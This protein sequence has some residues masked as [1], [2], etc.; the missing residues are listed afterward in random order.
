MIFQLSGAYGSVISKDE[1]NDILRTYIGI[2]EMDE[3]V[4]SGSLIL[5]PHLITPLYNKEEYP[6]RTLWESRENIEQLMVAINNIGE[7]GLDPEDYHI[8][9]IESLHEQIYLSELT[10]AASIAR[11]DILLTDAFILLSAHLAA[12]KVDP[13]TNEPRW[14]LSGDDIGINWCE[15]VKNSLQNNNVSDNLQLI[16]PRHSSYNNLKYALNRYQKIKEEGGWKTFSTDM[17]RLKPGMKHPDIPAVRLRLAATQDTAGNDKAEKELFDSILVEQVKL[18]QKR[19]GLTPRGVV[20]SATI[21]QM[22]IPVEERISGIKVNLDRWR[23]FG[24][25]LGYRYIK[26]NIPDF[27]LRVTENDST[28]LEARVIVGRTNRQTPSFSSVM[29]YMEFNPDWTVPPTMLIEDVLPAIREDP[30][31]LERNNMNVYGEDWNPVNPDTIDWQIYDNNDFPYYIVQEPGPQN[32]LGNIKF[33]FPNP[34]HVYIHDTP[35]PALFDEPV[36]TFSSGCIRVDKPVEL[37]AYLLEDSPVWTPKY[38]EIVMEVGLEITVNIL[39]P[40]Q[41]YIIYSTAWAGDEGLVYFRDDIYE[42]D[43]KLFTALKQPPPG[44]IQY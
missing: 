28:M 32:P 17:T 38:I 10:D 14:H 1:L 41:V 12:G 8:Y 30:D 25:E 40:I 31:Y 39:D 37:A 24:T 13:S 16:T 7:E 23:R 42:K 29:T 9:R 27:T 18:F 4:I 15:F 11:F 43:D 6:V 33:M 35:S 26:V 20:D 21:G 5:N 44:Y 19:K 3:P 36:R 34:Y 22:N 2:L